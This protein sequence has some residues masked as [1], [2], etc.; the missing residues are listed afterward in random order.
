MSVETN[1]R[2]AMAAAVAP[3]HPDT[4]QLVS[5]SR[6]RGLGIR[7]RRQALGSVGVAAALG[8]AVLAPNVVAGD[9]GSEPGPATAG[10]AASALDPSVTRPF[11]GRS[12]A[13]AL[14]Y[15]VNEQVAGT[16]AGFHGQETVGQHPESYAYFRFTPAG[17]DTAGEVGVNVQP[18]FGVGDVPKGVAGEKATVSEPATSDCQDWMEQCV[19]TTLADGSKVTTYEEYSHYTAQRGVRRVA[20]VYRPDGVRI[21]ASA[22]NG[23]HV[24]ERNE[25]ITRPDPV[26]TAAQLTAIVTQPWWGPELPKLFADQGRE[27]AYAAIGGA[28]RPTAAPSVKR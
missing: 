9:R 18:D 8:L 22:S 14:A 5:A 4:D 27:L 2:D 3:T 7:R 26:L 20:A 11:T 25:E 13:A 16:A 19:A 21:I 10:D 1:L 12:T 28:A 23:F 15:A 17:S 24:S 6:R